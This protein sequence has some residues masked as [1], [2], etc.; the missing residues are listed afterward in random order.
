MLAKISA[1]ILANISSNNLNKIFNKILANL[2]IL[3]EI[4]AEVLLLLKLKITK[5]LLRT[6]FNFSHIIA[7]VLLNVF[8]RAW[9]SFKLS[10]VLITSLII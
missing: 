6:C 3:P 9:S 7:K 10:L 5:I 8:V 4:I 1:R 2:Y